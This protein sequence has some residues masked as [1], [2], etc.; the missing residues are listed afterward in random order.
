MCTVPRWITRESDGATCILRTAERIRP[1]YSAESGE[2]EP[3][4]TPEILQKR[5][6]TAEHELL[7][8]A[9][10]LFLKDQL[11]IDGRTV[12]IKETNKSL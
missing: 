5:V 8:K 3:N 6:M 2:I 4:D 10:T 11:Q 1:D 7:P 9:V 12:Q